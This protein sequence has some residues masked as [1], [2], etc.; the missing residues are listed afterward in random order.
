MRQEREEITGIFRR[1]FHSKTETG[2]LLAGL[3]DGSTIKGTAKRDAMIA[4]LSYRYS[5]RWENHARYG[6][7]FAFDGYCRETAVT[8]DQVMALARRYLFGASVG[9]GPARMR[10]LIDHKGPGS[11]LNWMKCQP[12]EVAQVASITLDQAKT[13]KDILLDLNDFERTR[14]ELLALFDRR[15]FPTELV[16]R[17]IDELGANAVGHIERDPF[18]MMI[19]RWP[20]AGFERCDA[21]YLSRG[22]PPDTLKRQLMAIRHYMIRQGNGS[23]WFP[24]PTLIAYMREVCNGGLRPKKV[25]EL[26]IRSQ[27]LMVLRDGNQLLIGT[28]EASTDERNIAAHVER[29]MNNGLPTK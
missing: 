12:A 13:V 14:M 22:L 24:A 10:L 26:G 23:T 28:H 4:G 27:R 7:Q 17:A 18:T 25:I 6:R 19:R 21:L 3:E 15:G 16:D 29:L 2:F 20:G 5:G 9:I 11:V 8:V 1:V